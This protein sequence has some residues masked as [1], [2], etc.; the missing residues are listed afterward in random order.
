MSVF[1]PFFSR[2]ILLSAIWLISFQLSATH[3]VGGYMAYHY[4]GPSGNYHSYRVTLYVYRDCSKDG[5]KDEVPFDKNITLCAFVAGTGELYNSYSIP[6]ISEISVDPPGNTS[7]KELANACLRQGKYEYN[8]ALPSSS[9]GYHLRWERCCRNTQNNL[10]DNSSGSPYQGQTYFGKIPPTNIQNSSPVFNRIPVPFICAKDTTNISNYAVDDVVNG[11]SADSLSYSFVTPW[12]GASSGNPIQQSCDQNEI[13]SP[14]VDYKTGYNAAAPFGFSGYASIDPY[15][16]LTTYYAPTPGRYAVAIEVKE[17]RNG[18]EIS[19]IRLD[20]QILV[21]DCKPNNKPKLT[22]QGGSKIWTV[23]AGAQLCKDVTVTDDVDKTDKVTVKGYG[24]IF[25]GAN[26]YTGTKATMTPSPASGIRTATARFCWQ[27]DCNLAR[28]DPYRV[29][30]E[31]YDDGCPPKLI[32][33]NVLIYVTPFLP[34]ETPTGP[35][36]VCQFGTA[37]YTAGNISGT[38]KYKWR[39]IGGTIIGDST[40]SSVSINWGGNSTGTVELYITSQYGCTV[41]VR[42]LNVSLLP[43]PSKPKISGTDTVCLN[44]TSIFNSTADPAVTYLWT[45]TGG[46]AVS[47]TTASSLTV[48]WNTKGNG[49]VTLTVKNAGGCSSRTDTFQVFV[50]HPN[51][52][53]L[54][55]P[56]SVCPNNPGIA[57]LVNPPTPASLYQWNITGGVQASGGMGSSITVNWGG[58]GTGWVKVLEI[59]KFGCKGD[60]VSLK[61]IKDHALAGQLPAGDTSICEFTKGKVY[62]IKPVNRETYLWIVTGG[63][64]ISGQNSSSIVVDWGAAGV[65]SVGVQSTAYDSVSNLPCSSPVRARIVNL[66]PVP[67]KM[68]INGNFEVC[69]QKADGSFTLNGFAGSTYNWQVNGRAFSGQGSNTLTINLDTFGSFAIRVMETTQYSCPGP[70]NDTVLIIHPKPRTSAIS[71]SQTI[72]FPNLSGYN[73]SVTGFANSTYNWWIDGGSFTTG[74][75]SN[76]VTVNWNGKQYS[77]LKVRETSEFGCLGDTIRQDVFVD[78]PSIECRLVTVDPPPNDDHDVLVY[79]NLINAPRYNQKIVI[80]RRLRGSTGAFGT[81][82]YGEPNELFYTDKKALTDSQSYEYRAVIINLCGD[83]LYSNQNTDVLLKGHKTGLFTYTLNFTDYL[84]WT[85]GVQRYELWRMLENKTGW[86]LYQTYSNPSADNF[87]NGK[88]H[89]GMWFRI[90]AI[91]NGGQNRESWSNDIKIYF[92]PVIFIPNAFTPD[93][94]GLN[95][96]FLPNTGGMKTYT[97]RIYNRWGQK[98]FETSNP[99]TG[100]DGKYE[101]NPVQEGVYVYTINYTDYKDTPYITKGTLHLIR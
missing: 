101:D 38:N 39:A 94:N 75:N 93:G 65:G 70:W 49:F 11:G 27:T 85:A 2:L 5:T 82:G 90:K 79:Y 24:D 98:L 47:S 35:K 96:T 60:T 76:A 44:Y 80:Q 62:S 36:S 74:N 17:W 86:Q 54:E 29:T 20:L 1:R 30:F 78:N 25:T 41:P 52:P 46:N 6:L 15:D 13:S 68:N 84:G 10:K 48:L 28:T 92:D 81:V 59:N 42:T 83:S 18:K 16:G 34:F 57:Y 64:I 22:Y 32:N 50:S 12:Q 87:S 63:T 99:E 31:A 88:E 100:W 67:G 95:E 7:C 3:L 51:T 55:G 4:N 37:T 14:N 53:P 77:W 9:T 61:V 69:Q 19:S 23:E 26:G 21:I 33:E 56:N 72:C 91:E 43:S 89:Y 58:K 73:Y 45:V 97:L 66:R 8:I 40:K 71:G